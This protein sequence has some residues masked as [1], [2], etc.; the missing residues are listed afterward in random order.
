MNLWKQG[1]TRLLYKTKQKTPL[2]DMIAHAC[3]VLLVW[4]SKLL[5]SWLCLY[6]ATAA[7]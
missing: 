3:G 7:K 2:F 6:A 5:L 1:I 4:S